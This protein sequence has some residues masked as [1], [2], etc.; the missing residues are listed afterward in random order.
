MGPRP[1]R[2]GNVLLW[3]ASEH[4]NIAS[5]G[6]RPIRRG[7][8]MY[9]GKAHPTYVLQW[10]HVQSDVETF[11]LRGLLGGSLGASMGPRPIRRGNL[12]PTISSSAQ[13]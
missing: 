3:A 8:Q 5:M 7:N 13:N 10:G 12:I 4:L 2:R 1:I 11:L 9:V 6:P